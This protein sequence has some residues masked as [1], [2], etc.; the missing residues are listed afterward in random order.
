MT[1]RIRTQ[2]LIAMA[3]VVLSA[4]ASLPAELVQRPDVHLK[5]VQV[6]GLGFKS[7]T[8]L[9]SFDVANPNP[10]PL[11]VANVGYDLKLDGQR[12]ATGETE[13][14]FTIPASGN[15][16]FAISVDLNLL[17]TAPGLLSTVRD[18]VRREI[19]YELEGRFG[20]NLPMTPVVR[21]RNEGSVRLDGSATS[22]LSH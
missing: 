9:L 21:Y 17:A 8:F 2:G 15:S 11:P 7:Q 12:F 3:A 10:F 19:P 13:S 14:D 6:V 16:E 1:T 5:N 20:V 22:F 18:G 4:C